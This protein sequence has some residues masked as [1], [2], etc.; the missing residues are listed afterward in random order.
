M[1]R[2]VV[3]RGARKRAEEWATVKAAVPRDPK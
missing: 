1:K 2:V 3:E